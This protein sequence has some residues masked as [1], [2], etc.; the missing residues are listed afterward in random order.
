M[1]RLLLLF[2]G[3]YA[4]LLVQIVVH[5]LGHLVFGLLTGYGFSSFRIGSLILIKKP[6]GLKLRRVSLAGT[7]GQCLMAPPEMKDG[8]MPYVLYN[9]GG[10]LM[11]LFFS[12]LLFGVS[13]LIA[14]Q[15]AWRTLFQMFAAIGVILA[16]PNGLP[17][18]G[19]VANDGMNAVSLGKNPEALTAFR[20][21]LLINEQVVQGKRL[22][23]MPEEWFAMPSE[24]GMKNVLVVAIAVFRANR[25]MDEHRFED[26]KAYIRQLLNDPGVNLEGIYRK[27][28]NCDLIYCELVDDD[29]DDALPLMDK[30]MRA[31]CKSMKTS[32]TILRTEYV[33][34]L[35][36]EK[37]AQKVQKLLEI[38]RKRAKR[39]PYEG[40]IQ[41]ELELIGIAE[42]LVHKDEKV[43]DI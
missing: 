32:P 19:D 2:V 29:P 40:E 27:L 24:E 39:Y 8:K 42:S 33:L 13:L 36:G 7:G 15:S 17:L 12:A 9:L 31:F 38:F 5:E 6:D 25:I 10:V 3:M 43:V 4:G 1:V 16:I 41:A 35:L 28:L 26:A 14:S 30:E 34:A 23:D 22:S 21:Q 37:D 20:T 11:N 18:N